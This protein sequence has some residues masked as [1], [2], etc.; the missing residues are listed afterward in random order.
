MPAR[1]SASREVSQSIRFYNG[2]TVNHSLL[3][4]GAPPSDPEGGASD[5]RKVEVQGPSGRQPVVPEPVGVHEA[6]QQA[7]R[8]VHAAHPRL[9]ALPFTSF[10]RACVHL[11]PR[12]ARVGPASVRHPDLHLTPSIRASAARAVTHL[13]LL[14]TAT[15]PIACRRR[16]PSHPSVTFPDACPCPSSSSS[17][18]SPCTCCSTARLLRPARSPGPAGAEQRRAEQ[19]RAER[20]AGAPLRYSPLPLPCPFLSCA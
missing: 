6:P 9:M 12:R 11:R 20:G 16:P 13:L 1:S 8:P 4:R 5:R 10:T 2:S 7:R 3:G 17:L 19:S 14:L 15:S 18:G